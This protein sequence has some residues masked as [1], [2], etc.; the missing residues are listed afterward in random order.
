MRDDRVKKFADLIVDYCMEINKEDNVLIN[1]TTIALPLIKAVYKKCLEV[2]AHPYTD[3]I[4]EGLSDMD[5]KYG[6]D[7][8]L[9][10]VSPYLMTEAN[11]NNKRLFIS[12][13][14]N[15][16][17]DATLDKA[18]QSM[19]QKSNSILR[20]IRN[21][22]EEQGDYSWLI[23]AYPCYAS[24]QDA[25]MSLEQYEDYISKA[26]RI[27]S[28]DAVEA[29]LNAKKRQQEI[30]DYLKNKGEIKIKSSNAELTLNVNGRTCVNACGTR[31]MP[32]GEVFTAPLENSTKGWIVYNYPYTLY[33]QEVK[34]IRFEYQDG[35][36]VKYEAEE[37][38]DAVRTMLNLDEGMKYIGEFAFGTNYEINRFIRNGL[39]DEKRGGTMHIANG[40]TLPGT[41]G[42]NHGSVHWDNIT[43]ILDGE[44]SADGEVF[45]RN[46]E[47]LI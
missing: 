38:L 31:N 17:G 19:K 32:D 42:K 8:F 1:T 3:I 20:N 10:S 14:Y 33:G 28:E 7:E 9:N 43:E 37:G 25:K 27:D 26:L 15:T 2:G 13:P 40:A 24:A 39:F 16:A 47:F 12:A 21:E 18:K 6:S 23:T 34:N 36:V 35:K 22:R 41:G 45:Y 30:I 4:L 5:I 44:V 29:W 46:G 11:K